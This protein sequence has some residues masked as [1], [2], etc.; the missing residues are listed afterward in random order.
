VSNQVTRIH[1]MGF[2]VKDLNQTLAVWETLF[3]TKAEIK[4]NA[5][6]QVRLGSMMIGGVKFVFNESTTPGSRWD[7]FLQEQGEGL[8]HIAFEVTD[9][10]AGC[11]TAR[12]LD[13]KVRFAEHKPMYGTI[14]NFIEK[15]G[16]HATIVEFMEPVGTAK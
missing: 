13:L 3:G 11:E 15:D 9:I 6:L 12:S 16:L 4:E 1:H 14:S 5:E 2:I 10:N 8:E 7:L